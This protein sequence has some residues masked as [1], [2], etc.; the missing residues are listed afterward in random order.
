M[1]SVLHIHALFLCGGLLSLLLFRFPRSASRIG[2]LFLAAGCLSGLGYVVTGAVNSA[3]VS[4]AL[5]FQLPIFIIG[6]A[7]SL[8]SGAYLEGHGFNRSGW[9]FFLLNLTV[10]AMAHVTWATGKVEFLASWELM[11]LASFGLVC[12]EYNSEQCRRAAWIY[13][14]ACQAGGAFLMALFGMDAGPLA[15]FILAVLGFGLKVGFPLLHVWL[16]EAHPAAPAPVSALMSGAMIPLGFYGIL[17]FGILET[18]LLSGYGWVLL[19]TGIAGALGGALFAIPQPNLKKLLAYSSIE[20]MGVIAIGLGLAFLGASVNLPLMSW[21]GAAGACLH[22]INHALLKGALFLGAGSVLKSEHTLEMDR[23]GGLLQRA[24]QSGF[25]FIL[26]AFGLSG[27]PPFN[28]FISEFLIYLAAGSAIMHPQL[29]GGYIFAAAIGAFIA[30]ALTGGLAAAAYAKAVSAVFLGEPRSES[31]G[32]AR[33]VPMSM[34]LAVMLLTVLSLCVVASA[35]PLAAHCLPELPLLAAESAGDA[36][37]KC[38]HLSGVLPILGKVSAFSLV[39][40][41]SSAL[42]IWFRIRR[43]PYRK[44]L[45]WD[46][47]FAEPTARMEYTGTAFAQTITDFFAGLLAPKK[48][49]RKPE[50]LFP[51]EL[52][53]EEKI[54]DRGISLLW[55]PIFNAVSVLSGKLHRLQSGS[56]HFYIL[57][58]TVTLIIMLFYGLVLVD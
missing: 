33:E 29:C 7:A 2:A 26:N 13:L 22:I 51:R 47:G 57:V 14:L 11:G 1:S 54:G 48:K 41:I 56:L 3:S 15:A 32:N 23:M 37:D 30:L 27:L 43:M 52:H 46:C 58:I 6:L 40:I 45:T 25:M 19:L 31:A 49:I 38:A 44:A 39:L 20:N 42:L 36:A 28:G 55:R 17:K 24:P 16:P 34:R 50:E 4:P 9:Y 21:C 12:Y 10:A 8:H 5:I 35:L 18:S 53:Y